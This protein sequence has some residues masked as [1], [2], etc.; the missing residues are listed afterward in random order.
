MRV[1]A[2]RIHPQSEWR[3]MPCEL[4]DGPAHRAAIGL[5]TLA[6]DM[7]IEPELNAFLALD[8]ACVYANRIPVGGYGTVTGLTNMEAHITTATELLVPDMALD[9]VAFGCTSGSMA[10]GPDVV[11]ER[12]RAARPGI[13]CSNPVSA[14]LEGLETLGCRR[15]ALLDPYSDEVNVVVERYVRER[16]FDIVD[17]GSFKQ[18]GDPNIV[19]VPPRA[20]FEAGLELAGSP[21]IEALFISCTA[22]RVSPVI[23][24]LEDALGKPVVSSN[25][26]LAWNCL[27]L[28]GCTEEVEGF[29]RLFA[30]TG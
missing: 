1:T 13:A 22:L 12:I 18:G 7:T 16:G 8:G 15:I 20:I 2:S 25:Q 27:R 6:N 28:A 5:V 11:A 14:A 3:H 19:R 4:D 24:K 17:K 26:A 30:E 9:V 23:G 10:I 29:G 21:D